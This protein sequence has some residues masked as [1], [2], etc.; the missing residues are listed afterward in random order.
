MY[1]SIPPFSQWIL[2]GAINFDTPSAIFSTGWAANTDVINA[3]Y[4]QVGISL[5]EYNMILLID[6]I[7]FLLQIMI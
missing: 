3:Q 2:I 7:A 4:I 1:Y 5:E 6:N